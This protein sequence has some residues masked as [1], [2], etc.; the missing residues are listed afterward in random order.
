MIRWAALPTSRVNHC[1]D[2]RRAKEPSGLAT[3]FPWHFR[4]ESRTDFELELLVARVR[5]GSCRPPDAGI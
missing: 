5:V 2:F 4:K 1:S 3:F